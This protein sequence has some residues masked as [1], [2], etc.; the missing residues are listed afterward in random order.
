M[1]D[2]A[3]ILLQVLDARDPHG[4]RSV[5]VERFV[6]KRG[7]GEKRVILIL[8]KI[9]LIPKESAEKWLRYMREEMP[10]VAFKSSTQAQKSNLGRKRKSKGGKAG[11][12]VSLQ[13]CGRNRALKPQYSMFLVCCWF[14]LSLFL[15]IFIKER[16]RK[17]D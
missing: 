12:V 1:V 16:K 9:D 4:T 5:D 6:L 17:R 14:F 11:G 13:E 10:T 15:S 2:A 3:D 7:S 8:N